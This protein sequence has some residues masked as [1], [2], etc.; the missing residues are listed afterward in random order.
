MIEAIYVKSRGTRNTGF[1][2]VVVRG[3]DVI[4]INFRRNHHDFNE[5]RVYGQNC[6]LDVR[7]I[8]KMGFF[9]KFRRNI[10]IYEKIGFF[11][12]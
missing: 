3:V 2:F 7:F 12:K 5:I 6:D 9:V 11:E 8:E 10:G 4:M 1:C